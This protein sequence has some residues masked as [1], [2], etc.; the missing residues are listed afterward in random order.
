MEV[1]VTGGAGYIGSVTGKLLLK[2]NHDVIIFDNLSRGHKAAVPEGTIFIQGDLANP[3]LLNKIFKD[4]RIECVIHFAAASL[5][6]ESVKNPNLYFLNNV[7]NGVNLLKAMVE[8]NVLKIIFSSSAAVYGVPDKVPIT[9]QAKI[10]P[11][12]PY[13]GTKRIFENLLEEYDKACGLKHVSLRYFNVAGAYEELGEDHCPETHLIPLILQTALGKQKTFEIFGDDYDTRDGTCIRDYIHIYDLGIAHLLAM[14][15][16]DKDSKVFNLGSENGV[17]VKEVFANACEVTKKD[18]PT[19]I[20]GRRAGD[21][22]ALIASSQKIKKEL[23]WQ[24][25]RTNLKTIIQDAW[26]WHQTHPNGYPE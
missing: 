15:I 9:E 1:L 26:E 12:N 25:K 13:G 19:K 21:P 24:P 22:P 11:I 20:V 2:E 6:E 7:V 23:G 10:N 3:V 16:L 4:H 14:K 17:T 18:I 8:N 5:V